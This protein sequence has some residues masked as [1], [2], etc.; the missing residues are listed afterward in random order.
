MRKFTDSG[1]NSKCQIQSQTEQDLREAVIVTMSQF[2][3]SKMRKDI[4]FS[5]VKNFSPLR[6]KGKHATPYS[7]W[8]P[9]ECRCGWECTC[10]LASR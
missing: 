4:G 9:H 3:F 5:P 7:Q 8:N 10:L 2:F 1:S 6:Q